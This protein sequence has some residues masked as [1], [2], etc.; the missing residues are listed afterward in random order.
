MIEGE[1]GKANSKLARAEQIKAFGSAGRAVAG[2][3]R[4]DADKEKAPE[5]DCR[6]ISV[7][8]RYALRRE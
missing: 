5:A 7:V 1:I 8:D 4:D 3:R 6:K 2:E